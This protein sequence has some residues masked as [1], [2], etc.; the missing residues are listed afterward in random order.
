MP[1]R[2][3]NRSQLQETRAF[4]LSPPVVDEGVF[5]TPWQEDT[6]ASRLLR[7]WEDVCVENILGN[8][9]TGREALDPTATGPIS[10]RLALSELAFEVSVDF[11]NDLIGSH[12][13]VRPLCVELRRWVKRDAFLNAL[14]VADQL[15]DALAQATMTAR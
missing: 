10:E 9:S 4:S 14:S 3:F 12:R 2:T 8:Y 13:P 5:P 11:F 7:E 15:A 6:H 1:K